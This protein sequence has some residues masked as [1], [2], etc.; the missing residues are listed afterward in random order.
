MCIHLGNDNYSL[1][2]SHWIE[3]GLEILYA[4]RKIS[5]VNLTNNDEYDN[6]L[7]KFKSRYV[8]TFVA[9]LSFPMNIMNK[10]DT[11]VEL[12]GLT[13]PFL[14]MRLDPTT[15]MA[16]PSEWNLC[17]QSRSLDSPRLEYQRKHCLVGS[18]HLCPFFSGE[19]AIT[20]PVGVRMQV[21]KIRRWKKNTWVIVVL[22]L[23]VITVVGILLR[24]QYI[25]TNDVLPGPDSSS[26]IP[27]GFFL[28]DP[29]VLT[30]T[31]TV[32]ASPTPN[33]A[34]NTP[35]LSVTPLQGTETVISSIHSLDMPIGT[36]HI[37]VIHRILQ[38]ES[39]FELASRYNTSVET[40]EKLNY[41]MPIPV[42]VDWLVVI[43]VDTT[44]VSGLPTFEAYMVVEGGERIES[45]ARSLN[46]DATSL[47]FYNGLENGYLLS[48][49]EWLLIPHTR[50]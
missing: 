28:L 42:W 24:T 22:V 43:P 49:G 46:L 9:C 8:I 11:P 17:Y 47:K 10:P 18:H 31:I 14:G 50:E 25:S 5:T 21:Q 45:L 3:F 27:A 15:S 36:A 37:L 2:I 6:K 48:D 44:D 32:Y 12:D 41:N 34:T 40:I 38:G 1:L 30:P 35:M 29:P 26:T 13:C 39:L 16:Y 23:G 19:P 7:T 4:N 33:P 20:L